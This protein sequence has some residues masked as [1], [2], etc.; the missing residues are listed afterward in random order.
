MSVK[1]DRG[2]KIEYAALMRRVKQAHDRHERGMHWLAYGN[3]VGGDSDEVLWVIP[4]ERFAEVDG[5]ALDGQVLRDV[6]GDVE[7]NRLADALNAISTT[8]SRVWRLMPALSR[9]PD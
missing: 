3:A 4:F 6:Y 1:V 9:L 5:W 8:T 2:K 7:G